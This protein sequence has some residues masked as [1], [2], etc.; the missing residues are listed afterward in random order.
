MAPERGMRSNTK[1]CLTHQKLITQG[2]LGTGECFM[3]LHMI[4]SIIVVIVIITL[5]ENTTMFEIGGPTSHHTDRKTIKMALHMVTAQDVLG[6]GAGIK[7]LR[8]MLS[9]VRVQEKSASLDIATA[10]HDYCT[11]TDDRLA[12]YAKYPSS[13]DTSNAYDTRCAGHW[14]MLH[15]T[16]RGSEHHCCSRDGCTKTR[17]T[18]HK[19]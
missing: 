17:C 19:E 5:T 12:R 8:I 18:Q 15:D 9:N 11:Q 1:A 7:P 13:L 3:P 16:A 10:P 4:H 2:V 14:C 6:T